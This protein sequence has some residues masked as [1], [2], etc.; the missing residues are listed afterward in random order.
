MVVP[1]ALNQLLR[2]KRKAIAA[3]AARAAA[4]G[5]DGHEK[6]R[7]ILQE[8]MR[9]DPLA[10]FLQREAVREYTLAEGTWRARQVRPGYSL[11]VAIASA[12]RDGRRIADPARFDPDRPNGAYLHFGHG[13]HECF[14]RGI[15]AALLHRLLVPLLRRPNL[16]RAPGPKGRLTKR[17]VF[18][19]RLILEFGA[20]SA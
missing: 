17:G 9:F 2:P 12:M 6:L 7:R 13:L 18:A 16:C 5:S 15:N 10:P 11:L 14:G 3:V 4:E 8:A 20:R 19:E 1:Q